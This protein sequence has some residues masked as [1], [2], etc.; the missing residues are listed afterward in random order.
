MVKNALFFY[1]WKLIKK[2]TILD[3]YTTMRKVRCA[4]WKEGV[5]GE[6]FGEHIQQSVKKKIVITQNFN[7]KK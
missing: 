2:C 4:Q 5:G 3:F 1:N 6:G 7:W